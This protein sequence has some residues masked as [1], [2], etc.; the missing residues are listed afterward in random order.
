MYKRKILLHED[1]ENE[2]ERYIEENYPELVDFYQDFIK[3]II[4]DGENLKIIDEYSEKYKKIAD[5]EGLL[6]DLCNVSLD[7]II[8]SELDFS[9]VTHPFCTLTSQDIIDK[10]KDNIYNSY[11]LPILRKVVKSRESSVR[12]S[13]WISR[14]WV[15]QRDFTIVDNYIYENKDNFYEYV[16][17]KIH[18]DS[19]IRI[20]TAVNRGNNKL[21]I[22]NC[23]KNHPF[24][25]W[26]IQVDFIK[27][28]RDQHAREIITEKYYIEIEKGF[29]VFGKYRKTD[30]ANINI[31]LLA[32]VRNRQLSYQI[33]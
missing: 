6:L 13:K 23:F 1:L 29:A 22:E 24:N 18:K 28:K 11:S 33:V 26:N 7:K 32:D 19:Q 30:Q 4:I 10:T 31:S 21:G 5:Y 20:I 12:L 27:S 17:K 14:F 16:L 2:Y 8:L 15:D 25:Q 9:S 3:H